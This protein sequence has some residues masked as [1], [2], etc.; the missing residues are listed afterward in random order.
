[1]SLAVK[2]PD[3]RFIGTDTANGR[4]CYVV[5][6]IMDDKHSARLY[7]DVESMMLVRKNIFTKS[8][9]GNIP[10][11]VDFIEYSGTDLKYPVKLNYSYIDPW[12]ESSRAYSEVKYNIALDD[13]S[14]TMPTN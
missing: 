6:S 8:F 4:N 10:E 13:I 3:S 1:M 11:R 2:Y 14:F 5:R 9:L 7:F 12:S